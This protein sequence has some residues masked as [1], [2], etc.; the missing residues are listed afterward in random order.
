MNIWRIVGRRL[1]PLP[2]D[3]RSELANRVGG[4]PRKIGEW[5]ELALYGALACL[6]DAGEATLPTSAR[7]SIAS[8]HGPD[9]AL[10]ASLADATD[11]LPL[12]I[13]FLKSQPNQVLTAL[14]RRLGWHG[15][16]RCLATRGRATALW[17]AGQRAA[18]GGLLLGWVDED[19]PAT[20]DWLRVHP[21]TPPCPLRSG[22][23][24][25]LSDINI[26]LIAAD[27]HVL[28]VGSI[29]AGRNA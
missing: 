12:P 11:G 2:S 14:A 19:E 10:R 6:D 9:V 1:G 23:F 7:L 25:E 5:A 13:G 16:A 28:H 27:T 20:S 26:D 21:H 29:E 17:L 18:P 24:G 4:R 15:D 3:W 22:S 8:A